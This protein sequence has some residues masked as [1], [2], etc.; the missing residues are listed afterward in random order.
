ML[1]RV[2]SEAAAPPLCS[3]ARHEAAQQEVVALRSALEDYRIR[4]AKRDTRSPG[5]HLHMSVLNMGCPR[6]DMV[7]ATARALQLPIKMAVDPKWSTQLHRTNERIGQRLGWE[8]NISAAVP[9]AQI[10]E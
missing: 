8:K 3:K 6:G 9:G 1:R 10:P 2:R 4:R 5:H 7:T